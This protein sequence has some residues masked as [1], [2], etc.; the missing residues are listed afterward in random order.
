MK[1]QDPNRFDLKDGQ[2]TM[3]AVVTTGHG[4]Y[5]QLVY[6]DVPVPVPGPGEVLL[7]V[8]ASSVNNTDI[9][10]R[11]GWYSAAVTTATQ[12]AATAV[13]ANAASPTAAGARPRRFPSSRAP[14]AAAAW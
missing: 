2:A 8:L 9:N 14:T 12:D 11:L 7:Q 4:G 1:P 10:T 13:E 6:R 3:K 5:E